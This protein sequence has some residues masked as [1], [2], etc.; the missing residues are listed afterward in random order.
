MLKHTLSTA[1]LLTCSTVLAGTSN[2]L[3]DISP[4]GRRLLVTNSDNGSVTVVS[5][6]EKKKLREIP[7]GKKPEGALWIGNGPLAVATVYQEDKL[8]FFDA[9]QG[10]VVKELAVDDEP[11][12]IIGNRAGDR[13]W[14]TH[15]YPGLVSEIDLKKQSVIRKIPVGPYVRGISLSPDE[16]QLYVTELYTAK[17]HAV[18][19]ASAKVVD[20]WS[21]QTRDNLCRQVAIHPRR[22]KAYLPHIRSK[23]KVNHGN[24]SIF[25]HLTIYDLVPPK[26]EEKRRTSFSMD[27]FNSLTVV[28][29]PWEVALSPDAKMLFVVYAGTND[30][31][32]CQVVD[33]DYHEIKPLGRPVRVGQNP[34]AVKVTPDGKQVIVSNTLDFNVAIYSTRSLRLETTIAVC[35]PPKTPEWVRGK[36]LFNTALSPMTRRRWI[37]CASCHPDGHM[38]GRTWNNPEGRRNT[39]AMMGMAHTHPLHWSADRDEVQDFEYTIRGKLMQGYGLLRGRL[40]P[41]DGYKPT[42]LDELLGGRSKDLDALAIYCNSF[43]HTLSPH[44]PAEGKLSA[45][46]QKG[47]ELFFSKEVGCAKCH[48]GPYYSDSGLKKP[49]HMHDVGTGTGDPLEKMG[50]KF[51]TPS[52]LRVYR[53]APYLHDGRAKTLRDVLTTHNP[54]DL[55]GKTSHLSTDQIEDLVSFLKALPY[56]KPPEETPNS[57]KFRVKK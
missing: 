50:S 10:R 21:G 54:K 45:S 3:L 22:P 4:D 44:I 19:L 35:D 34:R 2:S 52:L 5:L 1:L 25:P 12:G 17:L 43:E 36:I 20:T 47:K 9:D 38:D 57:T 42:E 37:A 23:V 39:Q 33:D 51:D 49:F 26:P 27:T 48:S 55:H 8:V 30:M 13:A 56:V 28:N 11:Y 18:D 16:K 32:V 24:G 14:V 6:S 15:E 41:K 40:R 46:A 31:N 53:T 29:N 7:V